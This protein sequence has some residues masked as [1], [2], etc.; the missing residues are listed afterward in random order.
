MVRSYHGVPLDPEGRLAASLAAAA[1]AVTGEALGD[2]PSPNCSEALEL[3]GR[4][5]AEIALEDEALRAR[6]EAATAEVRATHRARERVSMHL[7]PRSSRYAL[8]RRI[9]AHLGHDA[10]LGVGNLSL[11]YC[12]DATELP[13]E[14]LLTT[15]E[16]LHELHR[17]LPPS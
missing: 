6:Y 13:A 9:R 15:M 17:R 12:E 3:R 1:R 4:W 10:G 16:I 11:D 14:E 8:L 2:C 7:P 5:D